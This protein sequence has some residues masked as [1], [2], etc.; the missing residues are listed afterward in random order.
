MAESELSSKE[1]NQMRKI[2]AVAL[3]A[4]LVAGSALS[5]SGCERQGPAER[6]GEQLDRTVEDAKDKL[7]PAGPAE[8][9][10]EKLDRAV[11]DATK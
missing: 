9:A 7:D 11:E 3:A 4:T 1:E 6:A 2:T 8:K 5:F 10:G